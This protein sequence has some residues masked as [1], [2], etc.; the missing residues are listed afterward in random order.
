MLLLEDIKKSVQVAAHYTTHIG[1]APSSKLTRFLRKYHY[2]KYV[3][4]PRA[5]AAHFARHPSL[6]TIT[7]IPDFSIPSYEPS[8]I[9]ESRYLLACPHSGSTYFTRPVRI[10]I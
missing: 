8:L 6:L 2:Q 3:S 4:L 9:K 10:F 1:I 7:S 5:T